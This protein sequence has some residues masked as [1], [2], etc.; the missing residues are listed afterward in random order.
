MSHVETIA[1]GL[2]VNLNSEAAGA[3]AQ[4]ALVRFNEAS[5]K[6]NLQLDEISTNIHVGGGQ[7]TSTDADQAS[8]LASQ[9]GNTM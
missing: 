5:T 2:K 3:A 7:Y 4:A 1:G 8:N 9:M 6:L